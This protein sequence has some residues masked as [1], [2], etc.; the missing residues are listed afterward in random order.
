LKGL[1]EKL[2]LP[3]PPA[4]M[5]IPVY[6]TIREKYGIDKRICPKCKEHHLELVAKHYR[7]GTIMAAKK[8]TE[9]FRNKASPTEF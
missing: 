4:K 9:Q 8:S 1:F 2:N 3:A 7:T 6:V 5:R